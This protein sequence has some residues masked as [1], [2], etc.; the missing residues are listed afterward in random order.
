VG[1]PVDQHQEGNDAGDGERLHARRKALKGKPQERIWYEIRP[2]GFRADEGVRRL[3]KPEDAG[4]LG[5]VSP[6]H[7]AAALSRENAV[8]EETSREES[9]G[10][11]LLETLEAFST[12]SAWMAAARSSG[13]LWRGIQVQERFL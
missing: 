10:S 9:P 11:S 8:G 2:A 13:E 5:E 3:R 4:E 7:D 12:E 1:S 6:A